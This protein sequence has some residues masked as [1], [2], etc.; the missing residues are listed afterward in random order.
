MPS[1]QG[2]V[3]FS[4]TTGPVH[5]KC[6]STAPAAWLAGQPDQV[7]E[8]RSKSCGRVGGVSC[9]YPGACNFL[10]V[11][12]QRSGLNLPACARARD[13]LIWGSGAAAFHLTDNR[14]RALPC[15]S[16]TWIKNSA[17]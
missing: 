1:A 2:V 17:G 8:G 7:A 9:A 14:R 10:L 6:R 3:E 15:V 4:S 11:F 12:R 13:A 16:A 5:M